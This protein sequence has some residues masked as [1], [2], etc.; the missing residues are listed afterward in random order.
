MSADLPSRA[1]GPPEAGAP[2][3]KRAEHV[4]GEVVGL[5][6]ADRAQRI[7]ALCRGDEQLRA[8]VAALLDAEQRVGGFL[9]APVL[10]RA[11]DQ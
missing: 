6:P 9:E 7:A 1:G 4:Y 5:S 11:F 2:L 10:G 8:A 3:F